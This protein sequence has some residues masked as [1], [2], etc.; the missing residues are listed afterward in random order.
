ME[1]GHPMFR[2]SGELNDGVLTG[3]LTAASIGCFFKVLEFLPCWVGVRVDR[4]AGQTVPFSTFMHLTSSLVTDFFEPLGYYQHYM[5]RRIPKRYVNNLQLLLTTKRAWAQGPYDSY[6]EALITS[7]EEFDK[8][9]TLFRQ[10]I[11]RYT[12]PL[13]VLN[14]NLSDAEKAKRVQQH[15][16]S[17][18]L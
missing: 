8:S 5:A 15:R 18:L 7:Q 2:M 3:V 16:T 6:I 4:L 11:G 14:M 9:P 17:V 12:H 10:M 1:A 13:V